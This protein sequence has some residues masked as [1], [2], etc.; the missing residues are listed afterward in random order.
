M[1]PAASTM[2]VSA[3][4]QPMSL[5][6]VSAQ[7]SATTPPVTSPTPV[8][9]SRSEAPWLS[10]SRRR[11]SGAATTPRGTLSQKIQCQSI[12]SVTTAPTTGPSATARP[13]RPP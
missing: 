4:V 2:T 5:A 12:P 13:A 3:F 11:E 10:G 7:T 8:R 6:R 1:P 9:S